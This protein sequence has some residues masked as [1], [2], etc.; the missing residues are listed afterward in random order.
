MVERSK[1]SNI[2]VVKYEKKEKELWKH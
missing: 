1:L 2:E